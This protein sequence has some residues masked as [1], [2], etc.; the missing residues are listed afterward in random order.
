LLNKEIN[1]G[2]ADRTLNTR[3]T[4]LGGTALKGTPAEFEKLFVGDTEKWARVMR[5][6]NIRAE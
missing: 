3:L 5:A 2:L 1:A 6:A 4:E